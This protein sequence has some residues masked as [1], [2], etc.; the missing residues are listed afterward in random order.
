MYLPLDTPSESDYRRTKWSVVQR[1]KVSQ[2]REPDR[3]FNLMTGQVEEKLPPVTHIQSVVNIMSFED[4]PEISI[5]E[6]P[7]IQ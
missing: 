1:A 4:S 7:E 2:Y 3:T 5:K 6:T